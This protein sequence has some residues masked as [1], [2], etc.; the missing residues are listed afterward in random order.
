MND[1]SINIDY[2]NLLTFNAVMSVRNIHAQTAKALVKNGQ[3]DRA[4]E[5]LDRMQE[6]MIPSNFPLN[7]SLLPSLNEIAVLESIDIY[8][9][10]KEREKGL[11]LANM[12][13]EET[14]DALKLFSKEYRGRFL[15][16]SDIENSLSYLFYI[17]DILQTRGEVEE[18]ANLE[19]RARAFIDAL[20]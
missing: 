5:I 17:I 10:A 20:Q 18:A 2:Q 11:A 19:K 7:G 4:V 3:M 8:L 9:L 13:I 16:K 12:F 6:V 1:P 15:S 14:F